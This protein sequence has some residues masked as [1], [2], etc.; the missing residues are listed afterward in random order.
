MKLMW[1]VLPLALLVGCHGVGLFGSAPEPVTK[2]TSFGDMQIVKE[3]GTSCLRWQKA[4]SVVWDACDSLP[5]WGGS[6]TFSPRDSLWRGEPTDDKAAHRLI[7]YRGGVRGE[8]RAHLLADVFTIESEK[9]PLSD[10]VNARSPRDFH[11]TQ[12]QAAGGGATTWLLARGEE[13]DVCLGADADGSSPVRSLPPTSA[14]CFEAEG[15]QA[16][17]CAKLLAAASCQ[18]IALREPTDCV[19]ERGLPTCGRQ[20]YV[21]KTLLQYPPDVASDNAGVHNQGG[22]FDGTHYYSHGRRRDGL[23]TVFIN[24]ADGASVCSA[25]LQDVFPEALSSGKN[26]PGGG[27]FWEGRYYTVISNEEMGEK[28][29]FVVASYALPAETGSRECDVRWASEDGRPNVI[30][31]AAYHGLIVPFIESVSGVQTQ[32]AAVMGIDAKKPWRCRIDGTHCER[33]LEPEDAQSF[34][35]AIKP[36][37]CAPLGEYLLCS[38]YPLPG[39]LTSRSLFV[40]GNTFEVQTQGTAPIFDLFRDIAYVLPLEPLDVEQVYEGVAVVEGQ[41]H[42]TSAAEGISGRCGE[43]IEGEISKTLDEKIPPLSMDPTRLLSPC[44][45]SQGRQMVRRYALNAPFGQGQPPGGAP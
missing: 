24:D 27:Y 45:D 38:P 44:T 11:L 32:W 18:P 3:D 14:T 31:S 5:S 39:G 9:L 25:V 4:S 29:A 1:I 13:G 7:A 34:T 20:R 12:T 8:L 21:G 43:G 15:Q 41:L 16:K 26:H 23:A 28:G 10:R 36:Q 30:V 19:V 42:L 33:A 37:E 17:E 22:H 2:A 6:Q 40:F 35:H